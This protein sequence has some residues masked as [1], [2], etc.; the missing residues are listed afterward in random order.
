MPA[1][2]PLLQRI[3]VLWLVL[4]SHPTVDRIRHYIGRLPFNTKSYTNLTS[5]PFKIEKKLLI[6][7]LAL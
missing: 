7:I 1:F 3:T 6:V 5:L 4:I 2:T